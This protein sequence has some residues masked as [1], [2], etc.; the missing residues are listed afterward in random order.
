MKSAVVYCHLWP[1]RLYHIF[2]HYLI[3]GSISEK[4]K[5]LEHKMCFDLLYNFPR[6]KIQRDNIVNAHMSSCKVPVILLRFELNLNF[7][8]RF[9]KNTHISNLMKIRP[10]RAELLYADRQ[11]H[12]TKLIVAFRNFA[13]APKKLQSIR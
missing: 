6:S 9:S 7:L 8:D 2:P 12:M 11:A 1:V 5:V 3:N 4:K 13:N 10:A